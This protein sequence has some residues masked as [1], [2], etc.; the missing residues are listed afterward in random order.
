MSKDP[1]HHFRATRRRLL[2]AAFAATASGGARANP[3]WPNQ[4]VRIVLPFAPGGPF[5]PISRI[6]AGWFSS[7][8]GQPFVIDNRPGATGTIG[9]AAVARSAPDGYN[10]LLTSNSSIVVAPLVLRTAGI[11]PM[12]DFAPI[13]VLQSYGLYLVVN[14]SVPAHDVAGFVAYARANPGVLNYTSPGIG[15]GGHLA[16]EMFCRLAGIDAQ[17]VGFSGPGAGLVAI[18]R[19]DAHFALDSVGSAQGFVAEGRLRGLAL[20]GTQRSAVVPDVPTFAEAGFPDFQAEIWMGLWGPARLPTPIVDRLSEACD[21]CLSDPQVRER[22]LAN[23]FT[24]GGGGAEAVNA[25]IRAERPK[26]VEAARL[27]RL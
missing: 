7:R 14:P 3:A 1:S 12:K 6:V 26:W 16:T 27:A 17:H 21:A 9:A 18:S 19:G 15:S 11:D 2:G 8:F 10:L 13:S 25:R 4:P 22:L 20:T 5:E 24:P 23:S